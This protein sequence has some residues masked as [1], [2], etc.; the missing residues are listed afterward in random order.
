[1]SQSKLRVMVLLEKGDVPPDDAE[2]VDLE[3]VEWGLEYDVISTLK[4]MGHD[5]LVVEVEQDLLAIHRFVD[6]WK[7]HVAFNLLEGFGGVSLFDQNVISY[8][9]LLGLPYTGCNPRGL[10]VSRNKSL[11]KKVLAYHEIA[12]P[13]FAVVPKGGTLKKENA[14]TFPLFVKSLTEE[15]SA[16]ISKDSFVE[17]EGELDERVRY[18]HEKLGTDAL[19]E[20]FIDGRELYVGVLGNQRL[21]AFPVWELYFGK[22][23]GPKIATETQKFDAA[24]RK[25]RHIDSGPAR[26]LTPELEAKVQ[27]I[28]KQACRFLGMNGYARVDFRMNEK[29]EL[30]VLE[31]NANPHIGHYEDFAKSAEK[32]GLK[33]EELLGRILSLGMRWEPEKM[34]VAS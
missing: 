30:F 2:G 22:E 1:V 31:V 25:K 26:G 14:L 32:K 8:L 12:T 24:Y 7:P 4:K 10:M 11:S 6:K 34:A 17:N 29:G 19:V 23:E 9:E 20:A 21:E 18:I 3:T 28:A 27:E 16:G 33:Y 5:V 13:S 15:A